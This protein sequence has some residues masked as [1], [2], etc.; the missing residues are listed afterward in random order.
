[1]EELC[2]SG[3]GWMRLAYLDMSDSTEMCPPGF[4]RY[5]LGS[6]RVVVEHTVLQVVNLSSFHLMV[7]AIHKCVVE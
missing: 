4:R 5:S 1:M 7:S 3:G 2:G 6:T